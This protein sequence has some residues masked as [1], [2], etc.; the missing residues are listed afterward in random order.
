MYKDGSLFICIEEKDGE[1][2]DGCQNE[3]L[4]ESCKNES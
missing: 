4:L 1:N 2:N 3:V